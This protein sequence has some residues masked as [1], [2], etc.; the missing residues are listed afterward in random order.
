[1][2]APAGF[3][4]AAL[5]GLDSET[6]TSLASYVFRKHPSN[7]SFEYIVRDTVQPKL[8][9]FIYPAVPRPKL[10]SGVDSSVS[11]AVSDLPKDSRHAA[12]FP[13]NKRGGRR[14]ERGGGD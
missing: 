4:Q 8:R 1:M 3:F 5:N 2:T 13:Q 7:T 10:H 12:G 14:G 6:C 11:G 9:S